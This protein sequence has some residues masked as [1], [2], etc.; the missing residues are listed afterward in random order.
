MKKLFFISFLILIIFQNCQQKTSRNNKEIAETSKS[1]NKFFD[2]YYDGT[3]KLNPT[4]ATE[5]GDSRFNDLFANNL[6]KSYIE[7]QR[8]FFT[9][10]KEKLSEFNR[11]KLTESDKLNLDIL[12]W[13]CNIG[14]EGLNFK[15]ELLPI[16]QIS[17]IDLY[18]STMAGGTYIQP[19]NNTKDYENWLKRL[20]SFVIWCD[21]AIANMRRGMKTGYTLPKSLVHKTITQMSSFNS[22]PVEDHVY[23]GP[24][25]L[26]PAGIATE[27]KIR[28]QNEYKAMIE[29]KIIPI[30]KKLNDFL[31][32]EYLPFCRETSGINDLPDGKKYYEYLIKYYTTT[33]LSAD[34]IFDIGQREVERISQ[35]IEKIKNQVGFQGDLKAFFNSIRTNRNLMPYS[36]PDQVISHFIDIHR[37]VES[38]L[39]KLFDLVPKTPLE[40]RRTE[41]FR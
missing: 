35:E 39:S 6:T 25:K 1:L 22:G 21:T 11:D 18:I 23:Y 20:D 41:A 30:Y 31:K 8:D 28:L 10:Y 26:F 7:K 5:F 2:E 14:L 29:K 37:I 24:I 13:E 34:E 3:M 12:K 33:Q 40:V 27:D 9:F 15:Q 32:N 16:N 36:E 17:S 38:N 4:V 19:F